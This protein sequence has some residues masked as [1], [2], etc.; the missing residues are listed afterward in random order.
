MRPGEFGLEGEIVK[1]LPL[2]ASNETLL[3]EMVSANRDYAKRTKKKVYSSHVVEGRK[4]G[5]RIEMA[6]PFGEDR[7]GDGK[8][9]Q[10]GGGGNRRK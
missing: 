10:R 5:K 6:M 2:N 7:D 1:S 4:Q 8:V 9:D 3:Q